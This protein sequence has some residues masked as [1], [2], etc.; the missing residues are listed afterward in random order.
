MN[1]KKVLQILAEPFENG[2]QELFICNIYRN[3]DKEKVQFDFVAPYTGKN[4]KLKN[5]IINNGGKFYGLN[6]DFNK[7]QLFKRIIFFNK[8]R[9][10]L[11]KEKYDIV[12][13]NSVSLL[14]L[15]F[16]TLTAKKLKIKNIIVHSHNDGAD[17]FKYRIIK[18][19]S[20]KI[21]LKYPNYYFACSERA[22]EWKFPKQIIDEKK[23]AVIKNGI[24]VEK[25][26]FDETI[27]KQYREKF[28]IEDKIVIG[29][30]GRFEHQK[31]HEFIIDVF[32]EI[33]KLNKNV[34][35]MLIG[36][37]SLKQH[38]KEKVESKNLSDKVIFLDIRD[39]VEKILCAMDCFLFPSIF[40]GLG[41]A[42]IE[43]EN[44][45]LPVIASDRLTK[46]VEITETIRKLS[47]V[48][49]KKEWA[50][51]LLNQVEKNK[52]NDRTLQSEIVK[53]AGY[54]IKKVS[55][56]LTNFYIGLK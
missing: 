22:A 38:I 40:E 14:G 46:E 52:N 33:V 7:N 26:K 35:L 16:G 44:S 30:V 28:N 29:H 49:K 36:D 56:D 43:A 10:I 50:Q 4:E 6:I 2:G 48:M 23:Y 34:S 42:V 18:K 45:G 19:I 13:I 25:F 20:D 9:E 37:G 12:H 1:N 47:L 39:D 53:Q 5:E 21:L 32:E 41:I 27:R 55:K 3:I 54:D 8:L 17:S 15:L 11:K 31:N 24:D 51:V